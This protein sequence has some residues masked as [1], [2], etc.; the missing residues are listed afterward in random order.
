VAEPTDQH[1]LL[2]YRWVIAGAFGLFAV[3][4]AAVGDWL[5][6]AVALACFVAFPVIVGSQ[7]QRRRIDEARR[8]NQARKQDPRSK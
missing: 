1:W 4:F 8:R 7:W 2:R 5:R 3:Y 6:A